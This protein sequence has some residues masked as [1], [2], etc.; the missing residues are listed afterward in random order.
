MYQDSDSL[1]ELVKVKAKMTLAFL[2]ASFFAASLEREDAIRS[3]VLEAGKASV[4][5]G[6]GQSRVYMEDQGHYRKE[7]SKR[8]YLI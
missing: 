8:T 5:G 3:K 1:A 6:E 2:M 7:S 4:G